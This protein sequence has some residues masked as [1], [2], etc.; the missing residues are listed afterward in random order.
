ML[1]RP[2]PDQEFLRETTARFLSDKVPPST[3]RA[4]R[5]DEDGFTADYW[6]QGVELGWTHLL[7]PEDLGGGSASGDGI[8]DLSLI[9]YE[10]GRRAAPGPLL[11][12]AVVARAHARARRHDPGVKRR[13]TREAHP[14]GAVHDRPH[15]DELGEQRLQISI[16]DDAVVLRGTKR[17]VESASRSDHLLVTGTSEAGPTQVLV[18]SDAPGVSRSRLH[19]VDLTRRFDAVT[20][21]DV[22]LGADALVGTAGAATADVEQQLLWA[23][24][25]STAESVGA[26]QTAF[27]MT[28]EW[29]ADRYSFGRPLG[30]YQAI[31]HRMATLKTWLE[32]SHAIADDAAAHV[33]A[34]SRDAVKVASAAAAYVG[35][36]G[37]ELLHDCVQLHGGIGVTF[38]HDLHLYLRRQTLDRA[39]F[40]T[41]SA[42]RRRVAAALAREA[43]EDRPGSASR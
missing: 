7:V 40:G 4:L 29:T 22:R 11:V 15:G 2:S 25:V 21:D 23:L 38:E 5:A 1:V 20:F 31:K 10:F 41:P 16:Q 39:L 34:G 37:S 3:I 35:D 17:P 27:D 32:A 28:L 14:T 42:H 36:Q 18:P 8:V 43:A 33:A 19:S 13:L 12:N 30:S 24:V 9:A 26:M 6:R